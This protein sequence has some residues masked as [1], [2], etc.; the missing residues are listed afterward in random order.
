MDILAANDL[1]R[2]L[3]DGRLDDDKLPL[4]LARYVFLEPHSRCFFLE[5]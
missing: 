5:D 1:R 3:W 2:A 4:N